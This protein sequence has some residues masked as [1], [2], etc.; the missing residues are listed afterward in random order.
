MLVTHLVGVQEGVHHLLPP[1]RLL[2]LR[3]QSFGLG[4]HGARGRH[5]TLQGRRNSATSAMPG[6]QPRGMTSW[7]VG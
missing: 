5:G 1:L 3:L 2:Q 7:G 6:H 4:H